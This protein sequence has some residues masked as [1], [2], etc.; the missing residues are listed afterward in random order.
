MDTSSPT[1]LSS[2]AT[3]LESLEDRVSRMTRS[4]RQVLQKCPDLS[5]VAAYPPP[6]SPSLSF[7]EGGISLSDVTLAIASTE[8]EVINLLLSMPS[9]AGA[10]EHRSSDIS[11]S[12]SPKS[13]ISL[14]LHQLLSFHERVSAPLFDGSS[15]QK[16]SLS[17]LHSLGGFCQ[18]IQA[19]GD[20][21]EQRLASLKADCLLSKATE[22][23][24]LAVWCRR[25]GGN[26]IGEGLG[27]GVATPHRPRAPFLYSY[28]LPPPS[29]GQLGR[30]V[31]GDS[32]RA[33]SSSS[34]GRTKEF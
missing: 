14:L 28:Y 20:F 19:R 27:G 10:D 26:G 8:E 25:G 3:K 18:T 24:E 11:H 7:E 15:L 13:E 4:I 21:V 16:E 29:A 34:R 6:L 22:E 5:D 9:S 23:D 30:E 1:F 2:S 31:G 32:S 12:S 33:G 17:L